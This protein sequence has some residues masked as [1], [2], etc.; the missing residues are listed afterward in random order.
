ML[1]VLSPAKS[2]D[3]DSPLPTR[4]HSDARMLDQAQELID[5]LVHLGPDDVAGLMHISD[6]LAALNVQRYQDFQRPFTTRN[7]RPAA[8]LFNGDVYRGMQP[9]RF[10]PRD[11]TEAQKTLRILS[12]LYGVLRPLDLIQPYRLEM[13]VALATP[14]GRT[15]LDFWG[16]QIT[17]TVRAD[18][19]ASPGAPVLVNLASVE[20]FTSIDVAALGARVISPRFEDEDARG[21]YRIVSFNAKRA[22]GEM[23]A[24]LVTHRVRTPRALLS[25]AVSGFEYA[26]SVSA[27]D[28]PVFRRSRESF[29]ALSA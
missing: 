4:R 13:G 12:G 6:E 20:Y 10:G 1:A 9:D 18:L 25:Y 14:R 21:N 15:L 16:E 28:Q 23:A 24:W 22:R 11:L 2:L 17:D 8:Y 19:D 29:C 27:P 3:E 5:I 7:A 26:S